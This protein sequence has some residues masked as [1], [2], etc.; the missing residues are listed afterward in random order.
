LYNGVIIK[1]PD[2]NYTPAEMVSTINTIASQNTATIGLTVSYD[3]LSRKI[4]F[5]NTDFFSEKV[6]VTFFIQEDL[7]SYNNC[8]TVILNEFQTL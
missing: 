4:K 2:G 6:T 1:I 5:T 3:S 8:G 7:I